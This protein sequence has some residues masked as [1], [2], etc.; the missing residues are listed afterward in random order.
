ML[1][2]R[3]RGGRWSVGS[4]CACEGCQR[5]RLTWSGSQNRSR[6]SLG[7]AGVRVVGRESSSCCGR[8]KVTGRETK[9]SV[10]AFLWTFS[11]REVDVR[12]AGVVAG[13]VR[14]G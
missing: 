13:A 12:S 8:A 6:T 2:K 7:A 1:S 10:P 9:E 14:G 4:T 5:W 11:G 3:V